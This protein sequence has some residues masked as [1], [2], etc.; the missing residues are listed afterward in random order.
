MIDVHRHLELCMIQAVSADGEVLARQRLRWHLR[1]EQ[2]IQ[3]A[4]VGASG[5]EAIEIVR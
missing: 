4:G 1:E 2:D 5:W 3:I